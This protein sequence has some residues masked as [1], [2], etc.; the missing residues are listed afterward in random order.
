MSFKCKFTSSFPL[1]LLVALFKQ[2]ITF[3]IIPMGDSILVSDGGGGGS[4]ALFEFARHVL[5]TFGTIIGAGE[6]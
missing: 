3:V 5:Y 2:I 4:V 1:W 6:C